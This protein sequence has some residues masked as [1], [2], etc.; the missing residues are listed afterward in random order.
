MT[1][2]RNVW[3]FPRHGVVVRW[4]PREHRFVIRMGKGGERSV[5]SVRVK[6]SEVVRTLM[7]AMDNGRCPEG[8]DA[9]P[10]AVCRENSIPADGRWHIATYAVITEADGKEDVGYFFGYME[11]VAS[12]MDAWS[13]ADGTDVRVMAC[14][15]ADDFP[16]TG[17]YTCCLWSSD[18]DAVPDE[19]TWRG[20]LPVVISGNSLVIR[21]TDICSKLGISP[22]EQVEV[23]IR[24]RKKH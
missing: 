1:E 20:T 2:E 8:D 22:N 4:K 5:Q 14:E 18:Q 7:S 24:R 16:V 13:S 9:W 15:I 21:V 17:S 6:D 12:A 3:T 19:D 11:A 10:V 23:T